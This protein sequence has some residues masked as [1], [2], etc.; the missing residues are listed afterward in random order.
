MV[1]AKLAPCRM[2]ALLTRTSMHPHVAIALSTMSRTW[3]TSVTSA[4]WAIASPPAALISAA[5]LSAGSEEPPV[6]SLAPRSANCSACERPRPPPAPVTM[7]TLSSN[8]IVIFLRRGRVC[9][10][11]ARRADELTGKPLADNGRPVLTFDVNGQVHGRHRL[12][13][14]LVLNV[15]QEKPAAQP[16]SGLHRRHEPDFVEPVVQPHGHALHEHGRGGCDAPSME[17]LN[18]PW[19]I[20]PPDGVC[21]ASSSLV[22]ISNG[23]PVSW[24]AC[25]LDR[26]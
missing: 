2:P 16:A 6:P 10:G 24:I 22:R 1:L 11:D 25:E 3:A 19:A 14:A 23:S 26:L 13:A 8:R 17:R 18:R 9:G 20:V 15:A 5:T 12:P 7:T 4:P 21:V